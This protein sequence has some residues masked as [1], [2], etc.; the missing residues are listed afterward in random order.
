VNQAEFQKRM[1]YLSINFTI[2]WKM[3][4]FDRSIPGMHAC[5]QAGRQAGLDPK[6]VF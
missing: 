3:S 1:P 4:A 6:I 5:M 2:E